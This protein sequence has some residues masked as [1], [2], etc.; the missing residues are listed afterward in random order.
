MRWVEV[1]SV[2][3]WGMQSFMCGV[4]GLSS[5]RYDAP[6][7]DVHALLPKVTAIPLSVAT[8]AA[9]PFHPTSIAWRSDRGELRSVWHHL[10]GMGLRGLASAPAFLRVSCGWLTRQKIRVNTKGMYAC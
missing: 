4:G 9:L 2:S 7:S 10:H 6:S 8:P 3:A 1:Q 5:S